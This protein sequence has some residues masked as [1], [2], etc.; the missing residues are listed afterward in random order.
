MRGSV[1]AYALLLDIVDFTRIGTALQKQGKQGAEDL[2]KMLDEVFGAP[3]QSVE[4]YG[5]CVTLFAGDAF[6]TIFPAEG[7]P[8]IVSAVNAIAAHFADRA[9]FPSCAGTVK[10]Q[11]RQTV[12][13]GEIQW[14]IFANELQ[15][16]YVFQGEPM[17]ELAEL[18]ALKQPLIF[19]RGAA[20]NAG[21]TLFHPLESG[22]RP[23][24]RSFAVPAQFEPVSAAARAASSFLNPRFKAETPQPEIRTGA[25][26]FASLECIPAGEREAAIAELER[27][28]DDCQGLVNKLDATDKGLAAIILFGLPR[29][30]GKTLDQICKFSLDALDK[31][32]KLAVGISCGEVIAGYTGAGNAREYTAMGHPMNL[33]ARLMGKARPGEILADANFWQ[34]FYRKYSFDFLGTLNLKGID[35]PLRYYRLGKQAEAGSAVQVNRFAGR[36]TETAFIRD[37]VE[38]GLAGGSSAVVYVS[39]EPGIGK[40]R[41]VLE[42]LAPYADSCH[43][44]RLGCDALAAKPLDA[45]TQLVKARFYFNPQLP[46][47][48]GTAMFRALWQELAAGDAELQRVESLIASL[49]G[50]TWEN[51]VWSMLPAA[52]KPGQL[53]Q[54]LLLLFHKLGEKKPF[55]LHLDDGQWLDAES[56][57]ILRIWSRQKTAPLLI[58]CPCRQLEDGSD[59]DWELA[60]HEKQRLELDKLGDSACHAIIGSILRLESVPTATL[61]LITARSMGNPL[62]VEQLTAFLQENGNLDDKGAIVPEVGHIASFGISDIVG[63]RIDRLADELRECV[64][65][66]SVL[67]AEFNVRAL[68]RMLNMQLEPELEDGVRNRIWR[69]LDELQYIFSHILIRDTIYQRTLSEKLQRLHQL[70]AEA[71][72]AVFAGDLGEHSEEIARHY[73]RARLPVQAAQYLD[74]AVKRY[75]EDAQLAKAEACAARAF[76]IRQEEFGA[77][78]A[79]SVASLSQMAQIKHAQG[80]Y[81]AAEELYQRIVE[82]RERTLG[83]EHLDTLDALAQLASLHFDLARY[84]G[85]EPIFLRIIDKRSQ[86]L[87]SEDPATALAMANLANLYTQQGK[88]DQAE[89]LARDALEIMQKTHGGEH[90]DTLAALN[91]LANLHIYKGEWEPAE[92]LLRQALPG[93]EALRG[94]EHPD[95]A[96]SLNNLANVYLNQGRHADAEP[97]YQR[98]IDIY[99]KVLGARHPHT[100]IS[101]FNLA[102]VYAAVSRYAE[103]EPLILK[104]LEVWQAN[105]GATHPY[106]VMAIQTL[107]DLYREMGEQEKSERYKAMLPAEQTAPG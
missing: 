97:V 65:S 81:S 49:L 84:D 42:A 53:T 89:T 82:I 85:L 67:G 3:I 91:N 33:A 69:P 6:C 79:R 86:I 94:K 22:F 57:D 70:A 19:S 76:Q 107:S 48:V 90:P 66:A 5:G 12:T 24:A 95:L 32:P 64:I 2:S 11:V 41:L 75:L 34:E 96:M 18:A 26:C 13:Y 39:G 78:D 98:V 74:L 51:S 8:D 45:V 27:L 15:N 63:G 43:F 17:R 105:L 50:Y 35:T 92:Q 106:T 68:S 9:E 29:S 56:L 87:G 61:D 80:N 72:S 52:D 4:S 71:L 104:A 28:A 99:E 1:S 83:S 88:F 16:E 7:Q 102:A 21:I 25:F 77:E 30:S 93:W 58:V 47:P 100:A 59:L 101:W 10:L 46:A 54:A 103:A 20:N 36:E 44:F 38:R 55:L 60:G 62:F 73:E 14:Q 23:L 40:T 31:L 37:I